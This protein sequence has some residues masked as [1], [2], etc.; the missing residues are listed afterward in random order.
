MKERFNELVKMAAAPLL[1]LRGYTK[2]SLTWYKAGEE[3]HYLINLQNSQ[4]NSAAETIFYV[5]ISFFSPKVAEVTGNPLREITKHEQGQVQLRIRE[6]VPDA[7]D[8]YKIDATSDMTAYAE[9]FTK[10]LA[11]AEDAAVRVATAESLSTLMMEKS[12]KTEEVFLYLIKTGNIERAKAYGRILFDRFGK[13]ERWKYFAG[14]ME[15]ELQANGIA[16]TADEFIGG[17]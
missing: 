13:E 1:K 15:E 8:F 14:M 10:E 17:T 9:Q 7:P 12:Y 6:L 2:K 16:A 3:V 4:G 11:A 5:N